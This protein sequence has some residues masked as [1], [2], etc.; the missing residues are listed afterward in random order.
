MV[1]KDHYNQKNPITFTY[2][3]LPPGRGLANP[4]LGWLGLGGDQERARFP[5]PK[6]PGDSLNKPD[7]SSSATSMLYSSIVNDSEESWAKSPQVFFV[8]IGK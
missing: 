1:N 6:F 8:S 2:L 5:P 3:D 4:G 7:F